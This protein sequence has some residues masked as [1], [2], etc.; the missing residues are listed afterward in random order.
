MT[1]LVTGAGGQLGYTISSTLE[2]LH[3]VVALDRGELDLVRS[4]AVFDA[5][6]DLEPD[7]IINCA[8]YTNV[9]GAEDD[10]VTAFNVN[11]FGVRTLAQAARD[12]DATLVHYSTDFVFD[13][14][15]DRPYTEED[16]TNPQSAYAMS[17]LLGEWF[18]QDAHSYILRVESL[19]G[20]GRADTQGSSV[21]RMADAILEGRTV[22]AFS[23][24]TVS[25]SYA[26]DVAAAT[27]S[28]LECTPAPGVYHCVGSGSGTWVDVAAQLARCLGQSTEIIPVSVASRPYKAARPKFC[29]LSNAKLTKS[30]IEMPAWMDALRRYAATRVG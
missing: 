22:H 8:A 9:D 15:A 27:A 5:V 2:S 25:P 1:I 10:P 12:V 20:G 28:L 11:A 24:R 4:A 29:A 16:T 3:R 6:H 19:F 18:A 13:G 17:K 30:G 23:D 26:C 7:V 14:E 21:D